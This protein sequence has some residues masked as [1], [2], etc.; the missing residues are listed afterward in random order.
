MSLNKHLNKKKI[1]L[2]FYSKNK[3]VITATV[4]TKTNAINK[5]DTLSLV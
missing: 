3:T 5:L 2:I 4:T 1:L